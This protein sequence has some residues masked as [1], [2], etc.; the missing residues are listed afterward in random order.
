L[1]IFVGALIFIM[2]KKGIKGQRVAR[3]RNN[4]TQTESMFWGMIRAALRDKS[5]WWKPI[6][7]CRINA[8][9]KYT[10]TGKRQRYEYQ[11]NIC[12]KWFPD[13]K[14]SV[15]HIIPVG[16]LTCTKDLPGFVDRLFVEVEGL[17]LLCDNCHSIKTQTE[18]KNR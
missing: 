15:D 4:A 16:T 18:R 11:C 5:R 8:R 14:T 7:Q 10:G 17:Q 9:R 12:K 3:T 1:C 6:A 2:K 13:K